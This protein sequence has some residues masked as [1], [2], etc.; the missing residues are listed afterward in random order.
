VAA[1]YI[2][3]TGAEPLQPEGVDL[4]AFYADPKASLQAAVE[5]A[6]DPALAREEYIRRITGAF[7]AQ[8]ALA[9]DADPLAARTRMLEEHGFGNVSNAS[10]DA[11]DDTNDEVNEGLR[12]RAGNAI[13]RLLRGHRRAGESAETDT[14]EAA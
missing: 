6:D 13:K 3:N 4:E 2:D 1:E 7:L 5:G 8:R 14:Q 11:E 10:A 12:R 9:A